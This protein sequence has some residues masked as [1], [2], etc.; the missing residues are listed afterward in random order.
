MNKD[1]F[2]NLSGFFMFKSFSDIELCYFVN[3]AVFCVQREF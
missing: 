3:L 2:N 1:F